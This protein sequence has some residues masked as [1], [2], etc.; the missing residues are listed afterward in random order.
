MTRMLQVGQNKGTE[1]NKMR[2]FTLNVIVAT[3]GWVTRVKLNKE[4]TALMDYGNHLPHLTARCCLCDIHWNLTYST[5]IKNMDTESE[6]FLPVLVSAW[7]LKCSINPA[8]DLALGFIVI[9]D[10]FIGVAPIC[11]VMSEM[12]CTAVK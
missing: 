10:P 9:L 11:V 5:A 6:V 2:N 3:S 1:C 8:L 12:C 4:Q 7:K